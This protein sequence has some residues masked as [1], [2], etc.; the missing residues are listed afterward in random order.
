[1]TLAAT[2]STFNFNTGG[3]YTS[4]HNSATVAEGNMST[5]H[6]NYKG[7]YTVTNWFITATNRFEGKTDPFNAW[8]EVIRGGRIL[9]LQH[10]KFTGQYESLV[11]TK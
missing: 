7:K 4:I 9:H 10:Q 3:N 6:R 5:S 8:F 2:S 11:K 1:M